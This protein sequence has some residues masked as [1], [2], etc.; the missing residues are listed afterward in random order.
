MRWPVCQT[1]PRVVTHRIWVENPKSRT[2]QPRSTSRRTPSRPTSHQ[3][4]PT[5]AAASAALM[6]G[7]HMS[8]LSGPMRATRGIRATAGNGANGHEE[9]VADHD[10]VVRP[11]HEVQPRP[12]VQERVGEVEEVA[13]AGIEAAVGQPVDD[14]RHG[15]DQQPDRGR[16][17]RP[18]HARA[19]LA[20]ARIPT[21]RTASSVA[22]NA[23]G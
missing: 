14:E 12:A 19:S 10:H 5:L 17:A 1:P 13:A 15:D 3:H 4:R 20:R 2:S 21:I 7:S 23:I 18:A 22:Q 9:P 6:P 8:A 11:G 16:P